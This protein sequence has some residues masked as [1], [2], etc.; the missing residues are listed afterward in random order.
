MVNPDMESVFNKLGKSFST[1][2]LTNLI[3][4]FW[5][6]YG[7]KYEPQLKT[8]MELFVKILKE[9]GNVPTTIFESTKIVY[10]SYNHSNISYYKKYDN[11]KLIIMR[12][13]IYTP[14]GSFRYEGYTKNKNSTKTDN[15]YIDYISCK[16]KVQPHYEETEHGK[17]RLGFITELENEVDY[18]VPNI[19]IQQILQDNFKI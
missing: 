9:I 5:D 3:N 18:V 7:H 13:G 1:N 12:Y 4:E 17:S 14:Y 19:I 6:K 15:D 2:S 10:L 11:N 8:N 16:D